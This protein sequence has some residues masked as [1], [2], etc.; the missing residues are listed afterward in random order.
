[1]NTVTH[2]PLL[3]QTRTRDYVFILE[4]LELAF[5]REQLEEITE[6]WN[7]GMELEDIAKVQKRH[8]QEV[9]LALF[10]QAIKEKVTRPFAFRK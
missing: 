3:K 8:A 9:F 1:M 10:H 2:L 7:S 6:Q 5:P 4:D